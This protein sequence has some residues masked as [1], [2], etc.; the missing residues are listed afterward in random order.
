MAFKLGDTVE[1]IKGP[2]F[3]KSE[4]IRVPN[5]QKGAMRVIEFCSGRS[6]NIAIANEY[7]SNIQKAEDSDLSG[8]EIVQNALAKLNKS[9]EPVKPSNQKAP[10][11]AAPQIVP[12]IPD[13]VGPKGN[14]MY[15]DLLD[16]IKKYKEV[17]TDIKLVLDLPSLDVINVLIDSY[18]DEM[19]DELREYLLDK[20][21][22]DELKDKVKDII[23]NWMDNIVESKTLN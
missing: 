22:T 5:R 20:V 19:K 14:K 1:W 21:L 7:L 17:E 8:E 16:S 18:G 9:I 12:V 23:N 2:D 4:V 13:P 6:C 15:R 11:L 10:E 3:G